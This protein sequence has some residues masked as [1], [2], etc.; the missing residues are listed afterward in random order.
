[1]FWLLTVSLIAVFCTFKEYLFPSLNADSLLKCNI[2]ILTK[3][4]IGRPTTLEES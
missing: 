2:P 3:P 1:M 4:V